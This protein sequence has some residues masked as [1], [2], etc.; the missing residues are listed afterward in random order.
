MATVEY[1]P[2]QGRHKIRLLPRCSND[3]L[4]SDTDVDRNVVDMVYPPVVR[5]RQGWKSRGS[6]SK[7]AMAAQT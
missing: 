3:H 1:L 2:E 6:G 7:L 4:A 5:P